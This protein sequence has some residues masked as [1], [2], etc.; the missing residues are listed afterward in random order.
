MPRAK[1]T[2]QQQQQQRIGPCNVLYTLLDDQTQKS[3]SSKPLKSNHN[4][5]MLLKTKND[6]VVEKQE[7]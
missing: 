1:N 6:V 4:K 7:L 3:L 2:R 5:M